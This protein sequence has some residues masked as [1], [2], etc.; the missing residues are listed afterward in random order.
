VQLKRG[1]MS[2]TADELAK[3]QQAIVDLAQ[4]KR[5]VSVMANGKNIQYGQSQ[6]KDL[7]ELRNAMQLEINQASTTTQRRF[8]L[9]QSSKGL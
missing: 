2:Y 7:E 3:V 6:I 4:G 5:I 1:D 9:T 8:V